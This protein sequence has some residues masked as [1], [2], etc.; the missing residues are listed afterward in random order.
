MREKQTTG[1]Q[2]LRIARNMSL[3][4]AA[5]RLSEH[6]HIEVRPAYVTVLEHRG[7]RSYKWIEAFAVVY[8]VSIEAAAE[9]GLPEN[10]PASARVAACKVCQSRKETLDNCIS[11]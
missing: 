11:S 7:T 2:C 3:T 9:G 10:S 6:L 5:S 4:E 1:L 8:K